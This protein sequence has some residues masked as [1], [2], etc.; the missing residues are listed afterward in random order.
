MA[1]I[2]LIRHAANDAMGKWLAGWTPGVHLNEAGRRQAEALAERL[3]P[4]PIRAIYS[5]PLERALE[6]AEPLAR[7]KG[8]EI[9]IVPE[10]GEVRYGDWTG[11]S[12]KRLRRQKAWQ[13]LVGTI[14]R[15]CFPGGEAMVDLIARAVRAVETIAARH[16]RDVVALFTHADLIRAVTAYYLGMPLDLYH[17]LMIAPAS[18]T[19]FWLAE[20]PPLLLRL[21]DTGPLQWPLEDLAYLSKARKR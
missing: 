17:R 20:G 8:L 15:A 1:I 13:R 7:R 9:Q 3:A 12:L 16:P 5:S 21:N 6:T 19:I 11:K 10:L 18:V 4:L 14:S 2:L